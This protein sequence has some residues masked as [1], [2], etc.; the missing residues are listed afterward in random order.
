VVQ[1]VREAGFP[2]TTDS[3]RLEF[4]GPQTRSS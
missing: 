3:M 2:L 1:R 4:D